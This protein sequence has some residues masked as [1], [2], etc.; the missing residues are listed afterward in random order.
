M[1]R[2]DSQLTIY[3]IPYDIRCSSNNS[4][5]TERRS[6]SL[7]QQR[8]GSV[9]TPRGISGSPGPA[10]VNTSKRGPR[11]LHYSGHSCLHSI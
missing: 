1:R 5:L 7:Q 3:I 9:R 11:G 10:N 2:V 6:F 8:I 4:R